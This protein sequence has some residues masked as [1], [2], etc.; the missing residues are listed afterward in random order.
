MSLQHESMEG[1]G[2]KVLTESEESSKLLVA[3]PPVSTNVRLQKAHSYS[4][5][6]GP[7]NPAT[8]PRASSSSILVTQQSLSS[9]AV[10]P[11][12]IRQD[13]TSTYLASPQLSVLGTSAS[14]ETSDDDYSK[15]IAYQL[16]PSKSPDG[17]RTC[18]KHERRSSVSPSSVIYM[19]RSSS[20]ESIGRVS[21]SSTI[22]LGSTSVIPPVLITGSPTNNTTR[23]IRQS[24]QPES[25]TLSCCN[26]A[27]SHAQQT[28]SLRQ[29]RD[30]SDPIAGIATE[31]LRVLLKLH[32]N[33]LICLN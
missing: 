31:T 32:S 23:I 9:G 27:C 14:E 8:A 25:S 1:V 33:L 7:T 16:L 28:S 11:V 24:S 13:R 5:S 18:H 22:Q 21:P 12:L 30:H 19:P 26:T 29:L 2:G 17:C 6:N 10:K 15:S 20:K 3:A 4:A